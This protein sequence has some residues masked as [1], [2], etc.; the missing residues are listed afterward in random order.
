MRWM[1]GASGESTHRHITHHCLILR[2]NK[3]EAHIDRVSVWNPLLLSIIPFYLST[4]ALGRLL[5]TTSSYFLSL[6]RPR[7]IA[8]SRIY[9]QS[10][11]MEDNVLSYNV[12][13]EVWYR[14]LDM[15]LAL[16]Y[17]RSSSTLPTSASLALRHTTAII[18][19]YQRSLLLP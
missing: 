11:D 13:N 3:V 15:C 17:L 16:Q 7:D 6:S 5:E 9:H 14:T 10:Y 19:L 18:F 8:Q 2:S 4:I 12:S 1:Y